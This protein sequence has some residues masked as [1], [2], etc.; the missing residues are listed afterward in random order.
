[1]LW[2]LA[3]PRVHAADDA[4]TTGSATSGGAQT[5]EKEKSMTADLTKG[6]YAHFATSMGEFTVK[7]YADRTPGTVKNFIDLTEGNKEYSD[8]ATG[9]MTKGR[10]YDKRKIF[11]VIKGFMFQTGSPND[12]NRY[13]PG[14]T[15]KDEIHADLRFDRAGLLAMANIGRPNSS[16]CQFFVTLAPAAFLDGQYTIFGE[17]VKGMDTVKK[18]GDVPVMRGDEPSPSLPIDMPVIDKVT[19]LVV[20]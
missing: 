8:P 17:V 15:I 14:F 7:L 20:E 19:I 6:S 11:R 18:I 3:G 10:L 9:K 16:G 2:G 4:A 12:T 1:M 13:S 5:T